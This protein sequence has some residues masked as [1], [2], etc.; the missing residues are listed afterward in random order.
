MTFVSRDI[1]I[2]MQLKG[3]AQTITNAVAPLVGAGR[4]ICELRV[5]GIA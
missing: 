3:D 1:T 5:R 2:Q 4:L